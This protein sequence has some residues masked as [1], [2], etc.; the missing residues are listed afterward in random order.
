M[1]LGF[2]I[3]GIIII[4]FI[5]FFIIIYSHFNYNY[6]KRHYRNDDYS[7]SENSES[8]SSNLGVG[9]SN[10]NKIEVPA[11]LGPPR[12][13]LPISSENKYISGQTDNAKIHFAILVEG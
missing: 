5:I 9:D 1:A 12:E 8:K 4:I 2:G 13:E 11:K 10:Y 7:E 6:F 3:F